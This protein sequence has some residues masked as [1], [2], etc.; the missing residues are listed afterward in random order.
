MRV[1]VVGSHRDVQN[2]EAKT[3]L[4]DAGRAIGA[5]LAER[6]H[7]VLVG[8][9]DREDIDPDVVHGALSVK[10]P[11]TIEVHRMQGSPECYPTESQAGKVR[12]RPHRY[13]DWD[14]TVLEV[15]RNDA[16]AVIALGGRIGVVQTGVAGWM[17]GRAVLPIAAF[18][19]GA[20]VVWQYGSGE[21]T[22][23]Y[24]G[25]L[26]DEE[27]D[28][29][30]S[31][32][33]GAGKGTSAEFVVEALE[34]VDKRARQA[35]NPKTLFLVVSALVL[36]TLVFWVGLLAAPLVGVL[37]ATVRACVGADSVPSPAVMAGARF[38]LLLTSVCAAGALGAL[39]QTLRGMREDRPATWQR[40]VIDL[41]LGISAG[42]LS[43]ALYLIA[44]IAIT[45]KLELPQTDTDYVRGALIVGLAAL[46][47]SL[48]LDAALARF[49]SLRESVM[50]GTY[51]TSAAK[52]KS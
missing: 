45:G 9:D 37:D 44:Q 29:L 34:R 33:D 6:G 28:R 47:S 8:S 4:H 52:E 43:A 42:F 19:G 39:M 16:D 18:G 24:F 46:F 1:L 35:R 13:K 31:S 14:V 30:M 40:I 36:F 15:L 38:L 17:L 41:V 26:K 22:G 2:D 21:R 25:A 11:T 10:S 3:L 23:F 7:S 49:D 48:Y 27:I 12:N 20:Q 51:G 50:A 32:W 5:R